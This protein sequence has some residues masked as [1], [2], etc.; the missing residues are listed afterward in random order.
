[1]NAATLF[2]RYVC[3]LSDRPA[4]GSTVGS[5]LHDIVT[6]HNYSSF[7]ITTLDGVAHD[8]AVGTHILPE[9]HELDMHDIS[10]PQLAE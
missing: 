7:S 4:L 8:F 2:L 9:P 5:S 6:F 10:I 1:M 3:H